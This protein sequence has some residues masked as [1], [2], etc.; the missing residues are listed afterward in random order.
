M[1]DLSHILAKPPGAVLIEVQIAPARRVIGVAATGLLGAL[2][3]WLGLVS[4]E[5]L[6]LRAVLL[7]SGVVIL[8]L[9]A[10][11]WE[12]SGRSLILTSERLS[13]SAGRVLAEVAGIESV[14]RGAFAVKPSNGFL[15]GTHQKQST[16]WVPGVWWR[17]GRWIGVGGLTNVGQAKAMAEILQA[18]TAQGDHC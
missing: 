17:V 8:W 11:L 13:D 14:Q 3:A 7:V 12:A 5:T 2:L 9:S 6:V 1:A 15:V 18:L 10:R 4:G 16:V